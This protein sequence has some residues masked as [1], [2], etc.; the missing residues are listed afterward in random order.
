MKL[1]VYIAEVVKEIEPCKKLE[2]KDEE[3][4]KEQAL[5]L[6]WLVKRIRKV[7]NGEIVHAPHSITVV[8]IP[9]ARFLP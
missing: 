1:L 4:G 9:N 3:V 8:S 5:S 7:I 6:H 2:N